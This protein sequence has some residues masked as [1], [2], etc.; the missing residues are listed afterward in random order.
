MSRNTPS[1]FTSS[2]RFS[3]SHMVWFASISIM[4]MYTVTR[5]VLNLNFSLPYQTL[6]QNTL[7]LLCY[8]RFHIN[9]KFP[10]AR[11]SRVMNFSRAQWTLAQSSNLLPSLFSRAVISISSPR[12]S[13]PFDSL[14]CHKVGVSLRPRSESPSISTCRVYPNDLA[15]APAAC[16]LHA[17]PP[18]YVTPPKTSVGSYYPR[19]MLTRPSIPNDGFPETI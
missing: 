6:F 15:G 1:G 4:K 3:V 2:Y 7:Y 10:K 13:R 14:L 5:K 12:S 19:W 18:C 8:L 17:G 11:Q 9:W 16:S